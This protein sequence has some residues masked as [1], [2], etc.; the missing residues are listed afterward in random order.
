MPKNLAIIISTAEAQINFS[1]INVAFY[2]ENL[3]LDSRFIYSLTETNAT[4]SV[5]E[6]HSD[7]ISFR[8]IMLD[9][10]VLKYSCSFFAKLEC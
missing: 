3:L 9:E 8:L 5:I 7:N 6:L 1:L 10:Y 2:T 4:W